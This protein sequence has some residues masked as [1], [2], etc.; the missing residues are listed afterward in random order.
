MA[1]VNSTRVGHLSLSER[2]ALVVK[3]V[4]EAAARRRI[5]KDTLRELNTLNDRELA[6][7]GI[8]SS[9]IH[10]IASEAAYGK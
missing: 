2:I 3:S 9:M 4:R 6:D 8:H 7:L 10:R 5:Y 1:Y